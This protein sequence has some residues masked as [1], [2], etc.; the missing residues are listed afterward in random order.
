[1]LGVFPL[2]H[3]DEFQPLATL[4][5]SGAF[6]GKN[7]YARARVASVP[8]MMADELV[9]PTITMAPMP[10]GSP[11]GSSQND[12]IATLLESDIVGD[13]GAAQ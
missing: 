13:G 5:S 9:R 11:G 12:S 7:D 3:S 2:G 4:V 8:A 1:M 6:V 10:T